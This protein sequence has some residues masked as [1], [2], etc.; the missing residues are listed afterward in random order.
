MMHANDSA[1]S[2]RRPKREYIAPKTQRGYQIGHWPFDLYN[3]SM[4]FYRSHDCIEQNT[5]AS[6]R[7]NTLQIC[8]WR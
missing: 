2:G 8:H 4:Q 6:R 1:M 7:R 3:F 5:W